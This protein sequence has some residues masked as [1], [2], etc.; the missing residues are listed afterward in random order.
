MSISQV[1][2]DKGNDLNKSILLEMVMVVRPQLGAVD[3]TTNELHIFCS[4]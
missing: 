3:L 4:Y 1:I 2:Y